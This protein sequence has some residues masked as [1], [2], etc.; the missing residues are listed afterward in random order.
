MHPA[1]ACSH[2]DG[3]HLFV[4]LL[5]FLLFLSSVMPSLS[6][7]SVL[8]TLLIPVCHLHILIDEFPSLT[9]LVRPVSGVRGA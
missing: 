2:E 1:E 8:S 3:L 5:A 4:L 7:L 9:F 6:F